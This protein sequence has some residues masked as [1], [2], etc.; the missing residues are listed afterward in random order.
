M[1]LSIT[2][3]KHSIIVF[4]A[5]SILLILTGSVFAENCPDCNRELKPQDSQRKPFYCNFCRKSFRQT[6]LA[7]APLASLKTCVICYEFHPLIDY[8]CCKF[9]SCRKCAQ[10]IMSENPS[11]P[12]CRTGFKDRLFQRLHCPYSSCKFSGNDAQI[13]DEHLMTHNPELYSS[14]SSSRSIQVNG[15]DIICDTCCSIIGNVG[16]PMSTA[17]VIDIHM[18]MADK[19]YRCQTCLISERPYDYCNEIVRHIR[20]NHCLRGCCFPGCY[21][22]LEEDKILEHLDNIHDYSQF[23][24]AI[25]IAPQHTED[26]AEETYTTEVPV[27][28]LIIEPGTAAESEETIE[29]CTLPSSIEE[30]NSGAHEPATYYIPDSSNHAYRA[31]LC[32]DS[33]CIIFLE[34]ERSNNS[35]LR[36]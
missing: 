4:L 29:L 33:N 22:L 16:D 13:I 10:A 7:L 35:S 19:I 27:E 26:A 31:I 11:C 6:E 9:K 2:D 23:L 8:P 12:G 34:Q 18:R 36:D 15:D 30:S 3:L 25:N 24:E 28:S 17:A 5:S 14:H 20:E 32:I 21:Y 1:N